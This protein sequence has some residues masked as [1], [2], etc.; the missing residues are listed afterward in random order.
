[1]S[2]ISLEREFYALIRL[3]EARRE[4]GLDPI[5]PVWTTDIEV[6]K[7]H[8]SLN[9]DGEPTFLFDIPGLYDGCIPSA[10]EHSPR[11]SLAGSLGNSAT[12]HLHSNTNCDIIR[13]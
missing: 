10:S 8:S 6:S 7:S 1:M 9:V 3:D 5:V 12:K 2:E 11:R 13:L 4:L